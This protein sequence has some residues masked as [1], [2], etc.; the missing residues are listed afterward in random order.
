M[1]KISF[2]STTPAT[3]RRLTSVPSPFKH[4]GI[5]FFYRSAG[6]YSLNCPY[7]P[8]FSSAALFI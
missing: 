6:A 2:N 4:R 8:V 1:N 3:I 7:L 5:H